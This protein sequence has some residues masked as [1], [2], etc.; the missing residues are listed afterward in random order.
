[1]VKVAGMNG[2]TE[3]VLKLVCGVTTAAEVAVKY[4]VTEAE[5]ERWRVQHVRAIERLA[6]P[7]RSRRT[8]AWAVA[9]CACA[10][11]TVGLYSTEAFAQSCQQTLPGPMKTFCPDTP[12]IADEVNANNRALD[13]FI[14]QKVGTVGNANISTTGTL[15]A[16]STTVSGDLTVNGSASVPSGSMSFGAGLRQQLNLWNQRFGVGVQNSTLYFRG[17]TFA[18]HAGGVHADGQ[19]DPGPGGTRLMSLDGQGNLN[20][21]GQ[22]QAGSLRRG[23]CDW[24]PMGP[25]LGVDNATHEAFC[26]TGRYAAGWRCAASV[27]LDGNCQM[28]CCTP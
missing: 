15:R 26:P 28:Y 3:D 24:G 7:R 10:G 11:L 12:A 22:L 6:R 17:D 2:V 14:E 1:L 13:T 9:F 25:G 21:P 5:V 23:T 19:A 4:D 18:W 20:V 8:I 16:G 27:Y